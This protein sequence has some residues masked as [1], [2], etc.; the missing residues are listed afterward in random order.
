M[1]APGMDGLVPVT[2]RLAP[3]RWLRGAIAVLVLA[4]AAMGATPLTVA[5]ENL[6]AVTVLYLVGSVS[7][8]EVWRR[9]GA[10]GLG[11]VGG[12]LVLDG[13][14]LA[15][16]GAATGGG[17]GIVA[18]LVLLHV[19]GVTL[20]VSYRT[21]VKVALWHSLL[22]YGAHELHDL[23]VITAAGLGAEPGRWLVAYAAVLWVVAFATASLSAVNERE[24]RR[25]RADLEALAGFA[26]ELD[27]VDDVPAVAGVLAQRLHT[28]F[29]FTRVVV[30]GGDDH[31]TLLAHAGTV[32]AA[33]APS[34]AG[35]GSVLRRACAGRTTLLVGGLDDDDDGLARLL[36]AAGNLV[37]V[38]LPGEGGTLGVVVAEHGEA[39]IERRVVSAL[40]R[41]ADH[42]ALALRA[43]RLL[44]EQRRLATIDGL[45]G[46]GNRR[47]FDDALAAE[48]SRAMRA[49][50]HAADGDEGEQ[51]ALLLL[52][53]DWFKTVN[54]THGHQVGDDVLRQVGATLMA[55]ARGFDTVARYGG[56]EFAVIVPGCD[57][58]AAHAAAERL[59][60]RVE[61]ASTVVPITA[62]VGVALA[63]EHADTPEVL[64]KAA[65]D[66][67]LA[68]K[69]AGRNRVLV[70]SG[71][72]GPADPSG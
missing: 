71:A 50:E 8:E 55:S 53:I 61:Q 66:A 65:D 7:L 46:T 1:K 17:A 58:A 24:L 59:R 67:L 52:D 26:A 21:G 11:S 45:T 9:T 30:L 39:R 49:S 43:A 60:R 6:V 10:S 47:A 44:D 31:S 29:G 5:A 13:V 69:A 42:G 3:V 54:D 57:R 15:W 20:L 40:E 23:G 14:Y 32:P 4:A 68:A 27:Q 16:A 35:P 72:D 36:P 19:A 70:A 62:S 37:V 48:V 56:E 41:F 38:P 28:T 22:L 33:A 63:P 25:G 18:Y 64:I 2:E 51:V 12:L 34:A